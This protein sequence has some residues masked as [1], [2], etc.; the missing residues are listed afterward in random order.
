MT[1]SERIEKLRAVMKEKNVDAYL[2]PTDDYH[3]SEYV[4]EFFKCRKY[5]TDFTG[6]AGT[7]VIMQDMA[8]LWTDGR[9]FI[10]AERQIAGSG[11]T[12]FKMGEPGVPTVD[13]FLENHLSMGQCLG[14]DGRTMAAARTEKLVE[15]LE[16][17]GV[18]I[19]C[20][21]DLIG[22]IWEDRP[23]MSCEPVWELDIMWSGKSRADKCQEIRDLMKK[24][25]KDLF[26]LTSLED[27]AWLLNIRGN[28]IHWLPGSSGL[29]DD[30]RKRDSSVC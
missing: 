1:V 11:V 26:L 13:E 15:K 8:G 27:I 14:F 3:C 28:D 10:Q 19:S 25:E 4:G 30:D 22:E 17:K 24:E 18:E 16:H 23:A 21:E 5:I 12:L 20:E 2:V 7:A 29:S 6:S 9:Y